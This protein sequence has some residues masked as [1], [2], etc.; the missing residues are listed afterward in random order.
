[1]ALTK[2]RQRL[3]EIYTHQRCSD[4]DEARTAA[5]GPPSLPN[6]LHKAT[7]RPYLGV[8]WWQR[9]PSHNELILLQTK[10]FH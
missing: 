9:G 3:H 8:P 5:R 7:A 10:T 4:G 6:R 2:E 1:M